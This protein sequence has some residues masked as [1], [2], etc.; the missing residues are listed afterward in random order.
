MSRS[1]SFSSHK[2]SRFLLIDWLIATLRVTNYDVLEQ[3]LFSKW[4]IVMFFK[5]GD[6]D[7]VVDE[8]ATTTTTNEGKYSQSHKSITSIWISVSK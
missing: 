5:T 1:P 4:A 7:G 3:L 6:V 8:D 2:K